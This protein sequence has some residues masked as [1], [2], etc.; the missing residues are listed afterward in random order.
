MLTSRESLIQ[1]TLPEYHGRHVFTARLRIAVFIGF[2]ALYLFF[3]KDVLEQT[4]E[5]TLLMSLSFVITAIAYYNVIRERWLLFSFFLELVADLVAITVVVYLTGGP[6]SPYFTLYIFYCFAAGVFY[7]YILAGFLAV[8]SLICYGA[9]QL[10]CWWGVIPPLIL[11]YGD[12][13]PVQATTPH[14]LFALMAV[15]MVLAVYGV[16]I[17]SYF[18]KRRELQLERRN[19]QLTSLHNMSAAIRSVEKLDTVIRSIL[20]NVIR[21]LGFETAI[22]LVIDRDENVVHVHT[23]GKHPMLAEIVATLGFP[24]EGLKLPMSVLETTAL[25]QVM[26]RQIVFRRDVVEATEGVRDVISEET[27]RMIQTLLRTQKVIGIP[28][29]AEG[30]VMGAMVG[31]ARERFVEDA[32]VETLEA[33][34]NQASLNLEASRLVEVLT[35]TNQELREANR[36]KS[37]FL[38]IMSHELRTPLT[39]IIGFSELLM[40]GVMGELSEEQKESLHEV[41]NNGADL[42]EMINSLLDLS[43]IDSGKMRIEKHPFDLRETLERVESAIAS[44]IQRKQQGLTFE[45]LPE[46]LPVNGDERKIQQVFLNLLS[47]A[48]KFTPTSGS[49]TLRVFRYDSWDELMSSVSW[50]ERVAS[51][52]QVFN[53]GAVVVEV[54]DT[55]CGIDAA[56]LESI[57]DMF[58]QGDSSMT[59]SFGGT[60]LGLALA[61]QFIELHGGKI[62]AESEVGA[63]AKFTVVIPVDAG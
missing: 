5:I 53:R 18:N 52:S 31:F 19:V 22:L 58:Q 54:Q 29:V 23:P 12:K 10:M 34:A 45:S 24:I 35:R 32:T 56:H 44:L 27:A 17:V 50:H 28:L 9:F 1:L 25:S 62:W 59:R 11:D 46:L 49:I 13:P 36:V 20:S 33:F 16:K 7:N 8:W 57:F 37:E 30:E 43:K 14:V 40:E 61:K 47:N 55:G 15:F 4:W 60:G 21:G 38:A 42:L 63:G 48:I 41:L 51:N 39:A 2:W 3:F 26:E 6:F